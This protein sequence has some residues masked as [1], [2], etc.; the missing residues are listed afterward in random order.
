MMKK[1]N[2]AITLAT[3]VFLTACDVGNNS[4]IKLRN[5]DYPGTINHRKLTRRNARETNINTNYI[6][7]SCQEFM[8]YQMGFPRNGRW[9]SVEDI[10]KTQSGWQWQGWVEFDG[11]KNNFVCNIDDNEVTAYTYKK[12]T[13]PDS[14]PERLYEYEN[15]TNASSIVSSCQEFMKYEMGFPSNGRWSSQ[16]DVRKTIEGWEWRGWIDVYGERNKFVCNVDNNGVR[17]STNFEDSYN[18]EYEY[19]YTY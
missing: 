11:E 1:K 18:Y 19:N 6:V 8:E 3:V 5:Y 2:L 17:V 15:P 9:S 13:Y 16:K 7:R 4:D 10:T 12:E 14:F